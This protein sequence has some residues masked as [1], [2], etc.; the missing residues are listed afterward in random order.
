MSFFHLLSLPCEKKN[1]NFESDIFTSF[2]GKLHK[3]FVEPK[4]IIWSCKRVFWEKMW[5]RHLLFGESVHTKSNWL[6][7]ATNFIFYV[8]P[9]FLKAR[10]GKKSNEIKGAVTHLKIFREINLEWNLTLLWKLWFHGILSSTQTI[11]FE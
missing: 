11:A 10:F 7:R 9:L 2:L 6:S 3:P 1:P 5:K 4:P 8:K